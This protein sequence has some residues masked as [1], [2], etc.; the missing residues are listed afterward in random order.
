MLP[1]TMGSHRLRRLL[2]SS[3][4]S[5]RSGTLLMLATHRWVL[6]RAARSAPRK[7]PPHAGTRWCA[8][9]PGT[10]QMGGEPTGWC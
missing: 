7:R 3:W 6:N 2:P 9:W 8:S 1:G 5:G 4:C 10:R